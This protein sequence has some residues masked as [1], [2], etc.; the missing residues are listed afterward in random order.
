MQKKTAYKGGKRG[1]AKGAAA[2]GAGAKLAATNEKGEE[3]LTTTQT[4][5]SNA[6]VEITPQRSRSEAPT[7]NSIGNVLYQVHRKL[8]NRNRKMSPQ[9]LLAKQQ[10]RQQRAEDLR[11]KIELSRKEWCIK[12]RQRQQQARAKF[13]ETV[14]RKRLSLQDRLEQAARNREEELQNVVEKAKAENVKAEETNFIIRLTKQNQQLDLDNKLIENEER[15]KL[16]HQRDLERIK[17]QELKREAADK[18]RQELS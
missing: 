3:V 10:E 1:S 9:K 15:R 18:R 12:V 13:Q 7:D 6:S 17:G 2:G 14:E 5:S 4:S 11:A 16:Q 8:M